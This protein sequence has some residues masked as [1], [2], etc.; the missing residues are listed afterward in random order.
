[1]PSSVDAFTKANVFHDSSAQISMVRSSFAESLCLESKPVKI[2]ITKVGG[3][4]EELA[5]KVYKIPI[6]T[7]DVKPVQTIQAVGIPQLS[8]E[9]EEL[10]TT[11]LASMFGIAAREV[12]R[13]AGPI[14]LLIGINYPRFHVGETIVDAS[15]VARRSPLGWVIF[16]SSAEDVM[17]E[18]K[19]VSL[20]SLVPPVDSTDFWKTESMGVS[21]SRCTCEASRLPAQERDE[22]KIIE[23]SAK[24]QGN[25]CIMKYTWKKDRSSLPDIYP[26]VRKKLETMERRLMK[27]PD[28]AASYDKQIKEME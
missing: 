22:M 2:L 27:H 12:R 4:E 13:K 8:N 23:E 28:N 10:D 24:L 3:V 6:C 15:L 20:V 17:P 26:K 5:T 9:V 21:V 14:D 19:Q 11:V 1:M 16:G 18:I 7:V 25:K